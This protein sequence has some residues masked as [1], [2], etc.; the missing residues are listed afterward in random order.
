[1]FYTKTIRAGV[2]ISLLL[3][4]LTAC[5]KST[6]TAEPTPTEAVPTETATLVPATRTPI[7]TET[8]LPSTTPEGGA[9]APTAEGAAGDATGGTAGGAAATQ[10]PAAGGGAGASSVADTYQYV[11]QNLPDNLQVRPGTQMNITWTIKNAGTTGWTTDYAIRY[12]SGVEASKSV[13]YLTKTVPAGSTITVSVPITAP[14]GLG[15]YNTWWKI[16]NPQGTNFGDVDFSFT[17]TNT[18]TKATSTP[19]K[20]AQ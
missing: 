10:A 16:T 7:P 8:P 15:S 12:F 5:A 19:V 6:P 18:P 9:A 4:S 20:P 14:A 1:M 3:G 11:G 13:Y 17:V 2:A